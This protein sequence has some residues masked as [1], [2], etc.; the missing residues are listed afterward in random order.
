MEDT[1]QK[2]LAT[3]TK[4]LFDETGKLNLCKKKKKKSLEEFQ[5]KQ[6]KGIT[7]AEN[8]LYSNF[9]DRLSDNFSKQEVVVINVQKNN[10]QKR[11]DLIKAMR[12]RKIMEKLKEKKFKAHTQEL[13]KKEQN[14][15]NEV[16]I[17]MFN[18]R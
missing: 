6:Q 14:F 7:V 18:R 8:L 12:N 9:L 4:I 15:I 11:E 13:V 2:E 16:A 3:L 17:N 5:T 1:C 10:E